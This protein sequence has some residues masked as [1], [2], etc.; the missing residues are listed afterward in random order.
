LLTGWPALTDAAAAAA[1]F[2]FRSGISLIPTGQLPG[3]TEQTIL[4]V[5]K[6][7]VALKRRGGEGS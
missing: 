4:R 5:D 6:R 2:H 3:L 7:W 1:F